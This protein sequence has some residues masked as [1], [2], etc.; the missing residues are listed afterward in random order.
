MT[1]KGVMFSGVIIEGNWEIISDESKLIKILNNFYINIV[2][3]AVGSKIT[4]LGNPSGS[5]KDRET[6]L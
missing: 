5:F 2:E 6:V 3:S 4:N 1:N